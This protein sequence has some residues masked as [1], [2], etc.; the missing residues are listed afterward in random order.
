MT[1]S[2]G[3]VHDPVLQ[4]LRDPALRLRLEQRA[5]LTRA[6]RAGFDARGFLE[7]ETGQLVDEPGQEPT[8]DPYVCFGRDEDAPHYLITSPE[9]RMKQLLGAGYSR[10]YEL[11][12]CFRAGPGE[13]SSIHDPEFTM[14]EWYRAPAGETEI[15]SD[16]AALFRD[17]AAALGVD[18]MTRDGRRIALESGLE[19]LTLTEAFLRH[20]NVDLEPFI[21]GDAPGFRAACARAGVVAHAS[22]AS[23]D[24]LFFRVLLDR[25]EPRLGWERPT[26]LVG[27]PARHAALARL[28]PADPRY[29]L[30]FE[31]Y[32]GGIELANGFV[33]L[34][35]AEEQRRRFEAERAAKRE[36]GRDPGPY[37]ERFQRALAHGLPP[38]AGIALGFDR[39]L[40]LL[41]GAASITELRAFPRVVLD[42][43]RKKNTPNP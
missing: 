30:R 28:D 8:L 6:I 25:V 17:G 12:H 2:D 36:S 29:A 11:V 42:A 9:L 39:L 32:V 13:T 4:R 18:A 1:A 10:I 21:E 16:V 3:D 24:S 27:Y 34:T 37:P 41:S 23:M 5:A 35:D 19:R 33:E 14:L 15:A 40:M 20:A 38:C 26:L 31:C 43:A 7:V 22:D